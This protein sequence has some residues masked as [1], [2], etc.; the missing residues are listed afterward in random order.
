MKLKSTFLS[1]LTNVSLFK[2]AT[3]L[4]PA[5]ENIT[6]FIADSRLIV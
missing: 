3:S 4:K 2:R 1:I 6:F 5:G